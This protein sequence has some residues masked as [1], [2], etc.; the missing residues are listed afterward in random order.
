MNGVAT[1]I[2][3]RYIVEDDPEQADRVERFLARSRVLGERAYVSVI[4]LCETA[5]VVASNY[6]KSK[7]EILDAIGNLL[8]PDV[9]LLEHDDSVRAALRLSRAGRG[10]FADYLIGQLNL[11]RGCRTTVTFDRGLRG[12]AGFTVL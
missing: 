12:A 9:F 6:G 10:D 1:N 2:L 5:W 7:S 11:D 4:V 8:D 3:L